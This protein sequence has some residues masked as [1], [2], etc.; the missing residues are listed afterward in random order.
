MQKQSI[1][2]C[3]NNSKT[4]HTTLSE[5]F[6]NKAYHTVR[7]IQEQSI[8]HCQNNYKSKHTTLS[9]HFQNQTSK[10][11]KEAKSM[12]L[13]QK[14]NDIS[15]SWLRTDTSIKSGGFKLVLWSPP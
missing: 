2:H 14:Q 1:P 12:P 3:Q 9:E 11:H 8:P 6:K 5:Q 7:T 15:L 13:A 10:S 4:K